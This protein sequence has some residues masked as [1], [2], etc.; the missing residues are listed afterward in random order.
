MINGGHEKNVPTLLWVPFVGFHEA[1]VH[2]AGQDVKSARDAGAE[3]EEGQSK[4]L[5]Y[6]ILSI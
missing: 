4:L 5:V 3:P 1:Q 2:G 6:R